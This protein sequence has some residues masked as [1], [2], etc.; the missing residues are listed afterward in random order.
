[1]TT[2]RAMVNLS[3]QNRFKAVPSAERACKQGN[4]RATAALNQTILMLIRSRLAS[5]LSVGQNTNAPLNDLNEI[6]F[7]TVLQFSR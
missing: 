4:G 1:M 7:H 3:V 6:Q 2:R 5:A